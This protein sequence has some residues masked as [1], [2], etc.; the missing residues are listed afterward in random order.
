MESMQNSFSH[1]TRSRVGVERN[2]EGNLK[3]GEKNDIN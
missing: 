2:R 3:E 1:K